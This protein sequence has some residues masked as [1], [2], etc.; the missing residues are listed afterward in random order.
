MG[1]GR[2]TLTTV[3]SG[4]LCTSLVACGPG[5]GSNTS[6]GGNTGGTPTPTANCSLSARQDF[7]KSQIDEWYLFPSL[8]DNTVNKANYTTVQDYIDALLAPARAQHKDRFFTYITSIAEENAFFNQGESAGFGVRLSYDT[9]AN[10]VFVV[11]AFEGAPALAAGIDRGTEIVGIGTTS[12]DIQSVASLMA[13]GG[14]QTVVD[15]LGPSDSGVTRVL[16][17][18]NGGT[19]STVTVTK[20]TYTLD[21]VS[22]RYGAKVITDGTKK[23]GYIN[24]RTFIDTADPD[25]RAAMANFK[26][27]GINEVIV[28]L[29][30]NG[31][32]LVAISELFGNLLAANRS[33]QVFS[34]TT[35]RASKASQNETTFFQAQPQSISATKIAF[36][37]MDGTAS[38]S[39]LLINSFI[40]YL[41]NNMAL[42]GSNTYGKPVGQIALDKPECDDRLRVIAF[43]TDNANHQGEYFDGLATVVPQ[44][45]AAGDDITHQLG[46]PN[47]AS[48]K[49]AIDFLDGRVCTPITSST[50]QH[51]LSVGGKNGLLTPTQPSAVQHE[52]PGSF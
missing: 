44:T 41:G 48:V 46:D 31:G 47:E 15:A 39:E 23:I 21:P 12:A 8:V 24:L 5:G 7:V 1:I 43:K 35:F 37:G 16:Q 20:A 11:E 6:G 50:G 26:S 10:R 40:P 2:T 14:A 42:V 27:Q 19:V 45:C 32:G 18:N 13:S 4:A 36:I 33:G 29:R 38:A 51:A 17:I 52:L 9:T 28:D 30:Y 22:N 34:Y 49:A 3:L 25:L